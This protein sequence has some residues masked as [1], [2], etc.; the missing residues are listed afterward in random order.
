MQNS[1]D[2]VNSG[3]INAESSDY[4]P[5]T[6]ELMLR[7]EALA[8][9]RLTRILKDIADGKTTLDAVKRQRGLI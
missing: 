8:Q 1:V 5:K 2:S 4:I 9:E 7:I 3:Q 6:F